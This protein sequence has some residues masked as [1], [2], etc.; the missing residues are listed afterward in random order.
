MPQPASSPPFLVM[1]G[2]PEAGRTFPLDRLVMTVGRT[3]DNDIVLN[4]SQISRHHARLTLQGHTWV[5]ED[6]GSRNGTLVN[7]NRIAGAVALAPGDLVEFGENA[8]FRLAGAF[9]RAAGPA[10]ATALSRAITRSSARRSSTAWLVAALIFA[11]TLSAILLV[12]AGV[13]LRVLYLRRTEFAPPYVVVTTPSAAVAQSPGSTLLVLATAF[14]R[15]PIRRTELWLDDRMHAVQDSIS[16]AG[17]EPL[18]IHFNLE[19]PAG[20]HLLVVRAI[21]VRGLMGQS[22]PIAVI[23]AQ[24]AP[25]AEKFA[26]V[27]VAPGE[28]L[29]SFAA[30]HSTQPAVLQSLNPALGDAPL[31]AGSLIVVPA[32][33]VTPAFSGAAAQLAVPSTVNPASPSGVVGQDSPPLAAIS[34]ALLPVSSWLTLGVVDV[35]PPTA[36]SGLQATIQDCK[37]T[38]SWIDHATNEASYQVWMAGGNQPARAIATLKAATSG[39][40]WFQFPAPALGLADFWVEAVNLWGHTP[41]NIVAVT[42][43][44]TCPVASVT[45]LELELLDLHTAAEYDR[46][47]A[48]VSLEEQPAVRLPTVASTFIALTGGQGDLGKALGS[49]TKW[50]VPIPADGVLNL[51]GEWWGW[52]G[53]E[54]SKLGTFDTGVAAAAWDGTRQVISGGQVQF[55]LAVRLAGEI[56]ANQQTAYKYEDPTLAVPYA[57]VES[58]Y[59][60]PSGDVDPQQR[61]LTWKWDGD[62]KKIDGFRI[63]LNDAPYNLGWLSGVTLLVEPTARAAEVR[64]PAH[65]GQ[66]VKWQLTAVHGEAESIPSLPVAYEQTECELY[67]EVMFNWVEISFADTGLPNLPIGGQHCEDVDTRFA[68]FANDKSK[69]YWGGT[70][71]MPVTCGRYAFRDLSG[72]PYWYDFAP[73]NVPSTDTLVV[74]LYGPKPTL[75]FGAQFAY[76]NFLGEPGYFG[77]NAPVPPIEMTRDEWA[78]FQRTFEYAGSHAPGSIK[79]G[80][81]ALLNVKVRG[82][83]K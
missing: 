73:Y 21:D 61:L 40:V 2:G 83:T 69:S 70:F 24:Q 22:I 80:I 71:F 11:G 81:S 62:S 20:V 16:A 25:L 75:R 72:W 23:G 66:H 82:F 47:Y 4:D 8:V 65:C 19:V 58:Q 77:H 42:V 37:V 26:V 14:G 55:G 68:I 48:Y 43:D 32:L 79:G 13:Y 17:E 52:A 67:A 45:Q 1:Q 57:L 9:T 78:G 30:A 60:S 36:P 12:A 53:Q 31:L 15:A 44:T 27:R 5:L 6:L 49:D 3:V 50:S 46:L 34:P 76:D 59:R 39:Q 35:S 56:A 54:L 74:P 18:T 29:A 41:S 10:G 28:D 64:L 33:P 7:G 63:Y 38:L 51:S